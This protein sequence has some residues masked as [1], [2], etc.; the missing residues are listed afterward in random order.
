MVDCGWPAIPCRPSC[1]R[2]AFR[3]QMR[4]TVATFTM[5]SRN[6]LAF[7]LATWNEWLSPSRSTS[8]KTVCFLGGLLGIGAVLGLAADHGFVT[9]RNLILTAMGPRIFAGVIARECG[10][11]GTKPTYR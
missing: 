11:R 10:G 5:V 3:H 9:L 2:Q 8:V 7:T 6:V 1:K 4:L